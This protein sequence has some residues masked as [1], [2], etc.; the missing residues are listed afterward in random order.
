MRKILNE[1]AKAESGKLRGGE[2]QPSLYLKSRK[3]KAEYG[4][5]NNDKMIYECYRCIK[6][7][8]TWS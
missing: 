3:E 6:F 7:T 1:K 8:D 5:R 4:L 2:E